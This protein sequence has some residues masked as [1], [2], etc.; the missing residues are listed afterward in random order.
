M[1][2]RRNVAVLAVPLLAGCLGSPGRGQPDAA[3]SDAGLTTC[4][5]A[6]DCPYAG[7]ADEA[8]CHCG[9]CAYTDY[10]CDPSGRRFATS[11]GPGGECAP[12]PVDIELGYQFGCL[13]WSDG[14]VSCW[15]SACEGRLGN[16][17]DPDCD[18]APDPTPVRSLVPVLARE[19]PG[20]D[21]V[22]DVVQIA[23]AFTT[24]CALKQ[25]GSV[26]CWG[27]NS[28]GQLGAGVADAVSHGPVQVVTATGGPLGSIERIGAGGFHFCAL[29]E[30]G[31]L[32]CWGENGHNQLGLTDFAGAPDQRHSAEQAISL[33]DSYAKFSAGGEHTCAVA[34]IGVDDQTVCWGRNNL[35]QT[36][37][38]TTM[39]PADVISP[40]EVLREES[41]G[42]LG[43][44]DALTLGNRFSCASIVGPDR[45]YC[46]GQ[47][48]GHALGD[49][50]VPTGADGPTAWL[51][52]RNVL[53]LP[54]GVDEI[55]AGDTFAC[56]RLYN[57]D[58]HCWGGN[59]SGQLGVG[60]EVEYDAPVKV[61]SDT[62]RLAA[63][64]DGA[65]VITTDRRV[66]C[67]G[68]NDNGQLGDGTEIRRSTPTEVKELC[69]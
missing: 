25:D 26:W 66:L 59:L 31:A 41:N 63:G 13:V 7:P 5:D 33:G 61:L 21:P 20:G 22:S 37:T 36:G 17:P 43:S 51:A 67:W 35:G 39:D 45:L 6:D 44:A 24:T 18:P 40:T 3:P 48:A 65:C 16:H 62:E 58:V 9:Q 42:S 10:T 12:A 34:E 53:E 28:A 69:Q 29:D 46:W 38:S 56:A 55:A 32:W 49:Q 23:A 2:R 68:A 27:S 54:T 64:F 8:L 60:S 1:G 11:D 30:A 47:N 14:R 19:S 4:D 52:R 57:G 15:G 50:D